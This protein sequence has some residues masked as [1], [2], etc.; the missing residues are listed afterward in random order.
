MN[1][2]LINKNLAPFPFIF[3]TIL[4]TKTKLHVIVKVIVI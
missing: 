4:E 1:D 2:A 3:Q